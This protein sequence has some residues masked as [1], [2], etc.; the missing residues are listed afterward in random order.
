M[1]LNL[2]FNTVA[3]CRALSHPVMPCRTRRA[4]SRPIPPHRAPSRPRLKK[5]NFANEKSFSHVFTKY[6]PTMPFTS[7][8]KKLPKMATLLCNIMKKKHPGTSRTQKAGKCDSKE[9]NCDV[10]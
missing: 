8:L 4:P 5:Q 6:T 10:C 3:P 7:T 2:L 1:L 9:E